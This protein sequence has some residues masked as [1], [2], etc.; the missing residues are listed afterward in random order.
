MR[1]LFELEEVEDKSLLDPEVQGL[2]VN[3]K[4]EYPPMRDNEI[5]TICYVRFGERPHGRTVRRALQRSP[6]AI[7]MFRRFKPYHEIEGIIDRRLAIV[8]LHSEGWNVKSIAGYLKTSRPTVYRTLNQWIAED[9][10]SLE[11]KSRG[12]KRKADLQAMNEVRKMQEN[13]ELGEFRVSAALAQMGIYLSPRTCGRILA[14]NR[15][16]YDLE[17]PRR[18]SKEKKEMP[19]QSGRRHE[20]WSVDVRYLE[21]HLPN[22]GKIYCISI[23]DNH[24][25]S[26]L[27]S[28]VSTTQDLT[29]YLSVLYTAIERYGAPEILV[30]DGASIFKANQAKAIYRSLGITKEVIEKRK[31]W[32]NYVETTFKIQRRMADYYFT[33]ARSWEE[34]VAAHDRWVEQYNTQMHWAH[35]H[36]KDGKRTP[37]E[38]LGFLTSI[39]HRPEDLERAFFSTRFT[40]ILN[41]SG[42]ARIR[43]WK[44]YAE[45]S[46]ARS[47]VTLWLG[48]EALTV[49]F[50]GEPL[51][52]YEVQ[53]SPANAELRKVGRAI[54]FETTVVTHQPKLFDLTE[55][56]GE[57]GWLKALR[58]EE[59]AMRKPRRPQ[60]L[61][62]VL[63]SYL[64]VV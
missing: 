59:Y 51:A 24:S 47:E 41:A 27:A 62:E 39:R 58:L 37:A 7:R 34:L 45:E 50:A 64:N 12:G 19:F 11:Y 60:M 48:P 25:R 2:I 4:S 16:L 21:H 55:A 31:P 23:L 14:V 53:Y 29:A 54:L 6:T 18:G 3:L 63:F 13:P 42:Y 15:A 56:L 28:A 57:K 10:Y 8:T 5:A 17:K 32:Q 20:I 61:Q 9:V 22:M 1:G 26:L 36:R 43:H 33:K 52:R 30:S 40:R 49:E 44:V 35:R 46:L 38:V